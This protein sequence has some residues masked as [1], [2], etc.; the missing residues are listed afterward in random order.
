M[1]RGAWWDTD[2][3]V[4]K[5]NM[6]EHDEIGIQKHFYNDDECVTEQMSTEW[7]KQCNPMDMNIS[8]DIRHV[9][10]NSSS[11]LAYPRP[12]QVLTLKILYPRKAFWIKQDCWSPY[13]K[14]PWL[15][16]ASVPL[17]VNGIAILWNLMGLLWGWDNCMEYLLRVLCT[18]RVLIGG[19]SL[20]PLLPSPSG[21]WKCI[22]LLDTCSWPWWD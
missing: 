11:I 1:D 12:S 2:Y 16:R 17:T 9:T 20:F 19:H 5:S 3:G 22:L 6:T 21:S 4:T 13:T 7:R 8:F 15:L 10:W 18:W 14:V